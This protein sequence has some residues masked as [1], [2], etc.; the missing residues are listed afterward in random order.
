MDLKALCAYM[1][2]CMQG[3][4]VFALYSYSFELWS[5]NLM[6]KNLSKVKVCPKRT[7]LKGKK[8]VAIWIKI[9]NFG[10]VSKDNLW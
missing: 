4:F 5:G 2:L 8:Y 9:Y 10:S 6:H 1:Y 7:M 3:K